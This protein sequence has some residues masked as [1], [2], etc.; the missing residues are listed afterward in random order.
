MIIN[1]SSDPN[2]SVW[3]S[4][5]SISPNTDYIFSAWICSVH[6]NNPA[7]LQFSIN[8]NLL[9][10]T[11]NAPSAVNQWSQFYTLWNSGSNSSATI[12]IVN[13]NTAATGNDFGIDDIS[14]QTCL[15]QP[16]S[17]VTDFTIAEGAAD[18]GQDMSFCSGNAVTIGSEAVSGI[19][20]LW[21]PASG[22]SSDTIP[23]PAVNLINTDVQ[24]QLILLFL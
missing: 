14:F 8:G 11:F 7:E 12:C 6:P 24:P 16:C 2:T 17:T 15:P 4:T 13:Q 9:G 18:A 23:D 19:T 5:V 10:S 22:L 21:T 20:Y 1:G 3:C